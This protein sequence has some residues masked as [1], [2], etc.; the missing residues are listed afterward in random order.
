MSGDAARKPDPQFPN[1]DPDVV[2]GYRNAP[3]HQVAEVLD[4]ELHLMPRPRLRHARGATRLSARLAPFD[5]PAPG[6]PG[7]WV[8][9]IE[10]ELH[11]GPNPDIIDPDIAGW[12]R[13]RV[14]DDFFS[15]DD[16]FTTIAPDWVCEVLDPSTEVV[17]RTKKMRVYRREG[18][19][20]LWLLDP[21]LRTLE[22]F[23]LGDA[24]Y[25]LVDT[26]EG[27]AVVRAEPFDAIE[28]PLASLWAR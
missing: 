22:V 13:E 18:V 26:F 20:R 9:L 2:E 16:A 27:D 7:G 12:R 3:S 8:I 15:D 14:P 17:D 6:D 28:L 5:D 23:R 25:A 10:P 24:L 1:L 19:G 4:G 21:A 11:L